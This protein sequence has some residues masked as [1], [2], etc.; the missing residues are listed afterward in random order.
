MGKSVSTVVYVLATGAIDARSNI[1]VLD[2]YNNTR[3]KTPGR[4]HKTIP[5]VMASA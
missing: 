4:T 5:D 1:R 2:K 3:S